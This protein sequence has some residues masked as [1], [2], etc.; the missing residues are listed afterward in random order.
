MNSRLI[1]ARAI[2]LA[3]FF[4]VLT[5]ASRAA[6][7]MLEFVSA[8]GDYIGLGQSGVLTVADVD[9]HAQTNTGNGVSVYLDDS[10]RP[11]GGN[12][13]W[14]L[15]FAAP[16][17]APLQ[18]GKY[19]HATGFPF[20]APG[21]PGI[22]VSDSSRGCGNDYG[23]FTVRDIAYDPSGNVMR[24]AADFE[25][26]CESPTA[27]ALVGAI[28]YN[29]DIPVPEIIA[30]SITMPDSYL[31]NLQG[32]SEATS[33]GGTT[34]ALNASAVGG[35]NLAFHWST[36]TG[37]RGSGPQFSVPVKL[38]QYVTVNLTAV[39][40]V[41]GKRSPTATRQIC[42]TDTTAPTV[43]INA[44]TEGGVYTQLP[45]FDIQV[46]DAV[47]KKI[48]QVNIAVGENASYPLDKTGHLSARMSPRRAVGNTVVTQITVTASDASNNTG[49]AAVSVLLQK[50]LP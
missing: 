35:A 24:F 7:N 16:N 47:D 12:V 4:S 37:R 49:Q 5:P 39:D 28:R 29:S 42:S 34:I 25:Q 43:Y 36:S 17:N 2:S 14:S 23:Q 50:D 26:H 19:L 21:D 22:A 45:V 27:A 44:P 46:V 8:P 15:D 32:C 3:L 6:Q 20:Q 9:F 10:T 31:P 33:P 38:G 40:Q 1:A 48:K 30:T 18:V 11:G 41:T 13:F